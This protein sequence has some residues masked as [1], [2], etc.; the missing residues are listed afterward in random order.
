MKVYAVIEQWYQHDVAVEEII[1]IFK[2]E[3]DANNFHENLISLSENRK[4]MLYV[5]EYEVTE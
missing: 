2:H 1:K 3:T 5:Q 4:N